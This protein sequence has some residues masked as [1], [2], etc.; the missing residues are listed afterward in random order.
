MRAHFV[1]YDALST[2][3]LRMAADDDALVNDNFV[4]SMGGDGVSIFF[5][6]PHTLHQGWN[7]DHCGGSC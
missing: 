4:T 1:I 2:T 5:D 6:V 3:V 7:G